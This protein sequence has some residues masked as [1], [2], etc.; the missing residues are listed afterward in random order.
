MKDRYFLDTNI[1][2]YTFDSSS[3][4][5]QTIAIELVRNALEKRSGII[6]YQVI[7]E[8]INVA[9][10]KFSKPMSTLDAGFYLTKVLQPL[11]EIF[12]DINLYSQALTIKDEIS[13]SFYDALIIS[14]AQAGDCKTLYSEDLQNG[15]IV[16]NLRITNPFI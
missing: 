12:P 10:R 16:R 6:S 8:F 9:L 5:K 3:P 4:K 1:L 11:C 7:Q 2:V 14:S 15:A 13:C